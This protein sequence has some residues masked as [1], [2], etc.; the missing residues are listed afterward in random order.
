MIAT[1]TMLNRLVVV[2]ALP[3]ILMSVTLVCLISVDRGARVARR[4]VLGIARLCGVRFVD[5]GGAVLRGEGAYVVV[6]N[7]SSPLDIAAVLFAVPD[8]RFLAAADLFRVPLLS[9]AMRGMKTIPIERRNRKTARR[10]LEGIV[11]NVASLAD[12]KIVIFP[13]GGI[14][15]AGD[16]LPFKAGAFELAIRVGAPILPVAIHGSD[17]VLPPKGRLGVRPGTVRIQALGAI[18]TDGL[19]LD[20]LDAVRSRA[21]GAILSAL[22]SDR[23]RSA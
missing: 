11:D 18:A 21:E 5:D 10:Q 15:P 9:A 1:R 19:S 13:E 12:F 3:L 8:V 22:G 14:P 7:H 16:R 2:I 4:S 6:A 20:D 17:R 23:A